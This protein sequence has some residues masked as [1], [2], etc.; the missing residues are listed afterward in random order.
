MLQGTVSIE[1][2]ASKRVLTGFRPTGKLHIGH[3]FGNVKNLVQLQDVTEVFV[4]VADWHMLSTDYDRGEELDVNTSDLVVDLIAAGL[5]PEK[6]VIYRQSDLPEVAELALYYS[7]IT[8]L[9]WL[10]RNPT[11]KEQLSELEERD[12][13]THGFLGYPLLQ[14]AD[15]TVVKGEVVPV[16]E[17]QLPHLELG[18]EVVRRFHNLFGAEY[19]PEPMGLLSDASRVP[20]NDGRKMSKSYGNAIFL[21]DS[22]EI[23]QKK[24]RSYIT[25]PQ[26]IYLK[27][28]GRPEVCSVYSLHELFTPPEDTAIVAAECRAG[29]RGCVACKDQLAGNL[30]AT[31]E[32]IRKRRAEAKQP[33]RVDQ[34]LDLG[35]EKVKP[36]AETTLEGARDLV[37]VG[38]SRA[39]RGKS[40]VLDGSTCSGHLTSNDQ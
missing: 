4:F 7:M 11:F 21:D 38:N 12:I 28:P 10:E 22:P 32:P 15:I 33:G 40:G 13:S 39:A 20:G 6:A 36:I 18:R 16:G 29:A 34:V 30:N 9:S 27:D 17:D 1:E 31:L 3:L 26:K 23:V 19:F 2:A 5:D 25:D 37:G 8:P 14:L 35:F 24:I